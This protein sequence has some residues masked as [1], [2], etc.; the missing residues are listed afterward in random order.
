MARNRYG[1]AG[2]RGDVEEVVER[3]RLVDVPEEHIA[4]GLAPL[5][6]P[7]GPAGWGINIRRSKRSPDEAVTA[8]R[9]HGWWYFIDGTD[10]PSKL[11]FR[12]VESL[13]SVRIA[14]TVDHL[15]ATPVLTVPVAC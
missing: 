8:V 7:V 12:I 11:T 4:S 2:G 9:H 1:A 14:D 10:A 6:P 15:K 13:L 3:S 5:L